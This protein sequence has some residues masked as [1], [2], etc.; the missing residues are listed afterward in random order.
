MTRNIVI[1][2]DDSIYYGSLYEP[3]DKELVKEIGI[4]W[5]DARDNYQK[6]GNCPGIYPDTA[7]L[8][9]KMIKNFGVGKVLEFGSGIS[10]LFLAKICEV[11]GIEFISYEEDTGYLAKTKELLKM[12]NI[13][14]YDNIVRPITSIDR[15]EKLTNENIELLRL[16]LNN[17]DFGAGL[18]F[19]DA[20][21]YLRHTVLASEAIYK[22]PFILFDDAETY[23]LHISKFFV[24]SGRHNF[25][26]FNRV[27]REDRTQFISCL[28]NGINL[29][30]FVNENIPCLGRW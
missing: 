10:T 29:N 18:I 15:I 14:N 30:N 21:G 22:I 12:Y 24:N 1:N 11:K 6:L 27:G 17:I 3:F 25:C 19:L 13:K 23:T 28:D 26:Y 8:F 7:L 9:V 5:F 4:S 16:D 20:S 2:N